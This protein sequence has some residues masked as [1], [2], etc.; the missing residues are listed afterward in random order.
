MAILN[1]SPESFSGDAVTDVHAIEEQARR[2]AEEGADLIDVGGLSTR[3][4]FT[5]I[6]IEAESARVVPAVQAVGRVTNLPVSVDTYR[7]EVAAAALDAGAAMINDV[8]GFRGDADL[9]ALIAD[10]GVPVVLMHNQ[11]DRA[12]HDVIDDIRAGLEASL[13]LADEAGVARERIMLDPGFGFGWT[14]GQNMELLKRLG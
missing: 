7:A 12:F 3:P 6:S 10:R 14:V 4:G 13:S 9:A 1:V 2:L 8:T 11:R 5:E